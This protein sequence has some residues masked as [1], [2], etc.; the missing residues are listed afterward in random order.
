M[1][2]A[3]AI[4]GVTGA[5]I[6]AWWRMRGPTTAAAFEGSAQVETGA[7]AEPATPNGAAPAVVKLTVESQP[8]GVK[9]AID[10]HVRGATPLDIALPRGGQSVHVD[11]QQAGYLPAGQDF[12]PDRDQRLFFS[13]TRQP[14]QSSPVKKT[15]KQPGFHR[16]N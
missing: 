1:L 16:F 10:G 5:A 6:G 7:A 12:T 15:T 13:L 2:A 4:A 14:A 8:L 3:I 11:L 9:V